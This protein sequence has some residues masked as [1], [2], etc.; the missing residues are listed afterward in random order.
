VGTLLGKVTAK[1][2]IVSLGAE[3]VML[4]L[5]VGKRAFEPKEQSEVIEP[6]NIYNSKC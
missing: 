1:Q 2:P 5:S 3:T 4:G 6:R